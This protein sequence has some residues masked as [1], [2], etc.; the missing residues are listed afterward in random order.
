MRTPPGADLSLHSGSCLGLHSEPHSFV[1][2]D[3]WAFDL[4]QLSW[5]T[6]HDP[7]ITCEQ[8][9]DN[10][11]TEKAIY[12]YPSPGQRAEHS[13]VTERELSMEGGSG[14]VLVFGGGYMLPGLTR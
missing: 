1:R 6:L 7:T 8:A 4:Q 14:S 3:V 11:I 13:C 12:E 10:S 5:Q 2:S 9:A